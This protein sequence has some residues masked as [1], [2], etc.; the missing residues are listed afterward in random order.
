MGKSKSQQVLI[1]Y[2]EFYIDNDDSINQKIESMEIHIILN[3][4]YQDYQRIFYFSFF[5]FSL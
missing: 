4:I 2:E 1:I 3:P 5:N